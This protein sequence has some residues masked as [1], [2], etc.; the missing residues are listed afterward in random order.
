MADQIRKGT[1]RIKNPDGFE[2][3]VWVTDG[4]IGLEIKESQYQDEKIKPD[5]E[6]LPWG[7]PNAGSN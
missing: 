1:H 3:G 5:L 7:P 6:T 4:A 2:D